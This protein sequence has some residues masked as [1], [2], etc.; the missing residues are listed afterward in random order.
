[1]RSLKIG[2]KFLVFVAVALLPLRIA[3]AQGTGTLRGTVVDSTTQQPIG[4][5]QV[6]LVGTNRVTYTDASGVYRFTGVTPG[7]ATVRVSK[8][9]FA[10]Q[11]ASATVVDGGTAAAD[12]LM[13][14]VIPTLSQVVVVGYGLSNR[15]EVTGALTTVAAS[16]IRNTPIAGIDA[17][18]Q[19][20]AAGVQVTQN[21]GNPGNG[22]SVRVRGAASLTASNQ[23]LYVVDGVPIQTGDFT[24]VGFGGQDLT[25]VTNL[26]PD[27]IESITVLKDA[28]SAGI[29]GSRAS[30][31]V[32]MITTKRGIAGNNRIS[33]NGYTG[34]Q[35]PEKLLNMLSG[36]EYVAYMAEG[37]RN[38]G[39]TDQDII[40]TGFGVG[41]D[42]Q[43]D[44]N[45]QSLVY[46]TAPVRNANLGLTGGTGRVKYYVS[47]SYFGQEGIQLATAYNRASGRA[48]IDID[49]TDRFT[50]KA[51]IGLSR[52]VNYRQVS[53]N[54]I[55][56]TG[57]NAIADQPN[58][59]VYNPDGT[60]STNDV[61]GIQ[62]TNPLAIATY[63]F[64]P[65]TTNRV[66]ANVEGNYNLLNW[67]QF[68]ARVSG[69]NLVLHERLWGSPL[70]V[71]ENGGVGGD[72]TS[73]YN[74]GSRFVGEGFFTLTPWSGSS[75]GTLTA[76][77]GAS[78]ERNKTEL[79]RVEGQGF[80]SPELHDVGSATSVVLYDG[81]R[82]ANNLLSYFARANL[83]IAERYLASAS[84]RADGSSRFGPNSRWGVFPA[85][86]L[87]WVITQEPMLSALSR[88]GSIKLRGSVG[89]TGNQGI[90]NQTFRETFGSSNYGK[91][92]GIAPNNFGNADLK[93][94]QTKEVDAGFDWTMFEGRIG[95]VGDWYRKKTSN[96]LVSRPISATSGF[97]T[98]TDN[99]GNIENQ[100]IEL[101]LS[102]D[103][104]RSGPGGFSWQATYNYSHN[105][106]R[107]TALYQDQPIYS[108][109]DG[110]NSVRVG[111][112]LGAFYLIRFLGVDP[113]TG[114]AIYDDVNGDGAINA[115]DRVVVGSPQPTSW[116]GVTNTFTVGPFDLR[117]AVQFSGGN[118]I[119]NGIREFSDDAGFNRDNKF[120]YA[121]RRWQNPGDITDEPRPSWDGTSLGYINSSRFVEPGNYTRLQEVTLG[122]RVPAGVARVAG[123]SN[124]RLYVSGRNL[125]TWTRFKGYNPDVNSNGSGSNIS[126][127]QEFYSYPLARTWMVGLSTDW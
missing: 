77:L 33:F 73:A 90:G 91:A 49:A 27:E 114:D 92:G 19:G 88:L 117:A 83:N 42:D 101:E 89:T 25:A 12:M 111:E 26:N 96:L 51:S 55:S 43:I 30:N 41:I 124:T 86:S 81:S 17:A 47:G 5:A 60:F 109:I 115:D 7:L 103:I 56:G 76:T 1:M 71:D 118:Q 80:S 48:N 106:N 10:Q 105:R 44:T 104:I 59:P 123:L 64:N 35:K 95:I 125:K 75:L 100:G 3:Q 58:M 102:S 108:G 85:F 15:S 78:T 69:D 45:W 119:W 8:I 61:T 20:K 34:W 110:V 52:E 63:D 36:P 32:V 67:M 99:V 9:G 82:S 22:I 21:A 70:V 122:M 113:Q 28:A 94:E 18:L 127:G 72:A 65:T 97:T 40:D 87:G 112:P 120:A 2:W 37:M 107:V 57:P 54:T 46:R 84:V 6:Q 50:V 93:W 116:G 14:T 24:Q 31:G 39:Y 121:L 11:T 79:N 4:G 29:Y 98:F 53:D 16:D 62:Y 23:P 126:L 38:D 68:T 66:L 13:R 74:T